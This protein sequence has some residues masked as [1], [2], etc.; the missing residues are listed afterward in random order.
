MERHIKE[1][2]DIFNFFSVIEPF[3]VGR[4]L[5]ENIQTYYLWLLCYKSNGYVLH[6]DEYDLM[7][8]MLIDS[9]MY[10]T[11]RYD[12]TIYVYYDEDDDILSLVLI[13]KNGQHISFEYRKVIKM[14]YEGRRSVQSRHSEG[15][16]CVV[17]DSGNIRLTD[18]YYT[19]DMLINLTDFIMPTMWSVWHHSIKK[20]NGESQFEYLMRL[21]TEL[22]PLSDDGNGRCIFF[23]LKK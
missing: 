12:G 19:R 6:G 22:E 14:Y 1:L 23:Y 8:T 9:R 4:Q 15:I 13:D 2:V 11:F 5:K 7:A 18:G 20:A 3:N 10:P 16:R 21:Y 17:K